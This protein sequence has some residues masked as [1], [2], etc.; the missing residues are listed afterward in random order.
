MRLLGNFICLGHFTVFSLFFVC[1]FICC[2]FCF[3]CCQIG[4][5]HVFKILETNSTNKSS[6]S[7]LRV[8]LGFWFCLGRPDHSPS[9]I[10]AI[11]HPRPLAF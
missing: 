6:F 1:L 11:K 10:P 8:C 7:F 9:T 2:G 3:S 4:R 5:R